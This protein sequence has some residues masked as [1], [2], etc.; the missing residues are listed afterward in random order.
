V[1]TFLPLQSF[2]LIPTFA[3]FGE[4]LPSLLP[5]FHDSNVGTFLCCFSLG[6]GRYL[7][8]LMTKGSPTVFCP[9]YYLLNLPNYFMNLSFALLGITNN[10][11]KLKKLKIL[12]FHIV[13]NNSSIYI[14]ML[15]LI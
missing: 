14:S 13:F 6:C 5:S 8:L 9:T 4:H 2:H 3:L 7:V 11:K 15:N 12:Y 10:N 1:C